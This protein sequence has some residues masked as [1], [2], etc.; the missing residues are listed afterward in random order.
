MF[1]GEVE[2]SFAFYSS[3]LAFKTLVLTGLTIIRRF[4]YGAFCKSAQNSEVEAVRRIL[5]SPAYLCTEG[6]Y[7]RGPI[8]M[9][10]IIINI[11]LAVQCIAYYW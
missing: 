9:T 6:K 10:A 2:R 7:P 11:S 5:H 3:L 1:I 4:R 8:A